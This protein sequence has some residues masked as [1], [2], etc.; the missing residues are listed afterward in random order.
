[1]ADLI[2]K[3]WS[4]ISAPPHALERDG[5]ELKLKPKDC[6]RYMHCINKMPK[7]LRPGLDKGATILISGKALI[8][9]GTYLSWVLLP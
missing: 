3:G 2:L 8:I 9:R 4:P 5:S 6:I 7:A 1:M